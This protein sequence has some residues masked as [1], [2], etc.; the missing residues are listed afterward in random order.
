MGGNI[1]YQ[2][3]RKQV[4]IS[5]SCQL[6]NLLYQI[7]DVCM[8]V[9]MYVFRGNINC[10][11]HW[12]YRDYTMSIIFWSKVHLFLRTLSLRNWNSIMKN[13]IRKNIYSTRDI[14]MGLRSLIEKTNDSTGIL[15]DL[16]ESALFALRSLTQQ[17]KISTTQ[18]NNSFIKSLSAL[19][20][21]SL[22]IKWPER[23]VFY[24]GVGKRLKRQSP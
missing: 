2:Q 24:Y 4:H 21:K 5:N 18:A 16:N 23:F 22:A 20:I 10:A 8:Y 14:I 15:T 11:R 19:L 9:C 17:L 12:N 13:W 6:F 3:S 1:I 7:K